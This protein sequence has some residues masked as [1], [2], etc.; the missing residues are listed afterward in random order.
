[1]LNMKRGF[2]LENKRIMSKQKA[3]MPRNFSMMQ[4]PE[5]NLISTTYKW[6]QPINNTDILSDIDTDNTNEEDNLTYRNLEMHF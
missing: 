5:R 4:S 3:H 6:N 2:L 1:M